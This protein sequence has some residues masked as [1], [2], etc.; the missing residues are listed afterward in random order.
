[1]KWQDI[2]AKLIE[3]NDKE[4]CLDFALACAET[5]LQFSDSEY[6]METLPIIQ[7][8]RWNHAALRTRFQPLA[9]IRVQE[10]ETGKKES[11]H[12]MIHALELAGVNSIQSQAA[13]AARCGEALNRIDEN[14]CVEI[15]NRFLN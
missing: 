8:N 15:V 14:L 4:I 3:R 6:V 11:A 9:R 2:Q 1:M 13:H 5:A 12:V 7:Q 10:Q